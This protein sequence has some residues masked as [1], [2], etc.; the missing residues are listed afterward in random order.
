MCHGCLLPTSAATSR[1]SPTRPCVELPPVPRPP[2]HDHHRRRRRRHHQPV[3]PT[4]PSLLTDSE[5]SAVTLTI[6]KP[7]KEIRISCLEGNICFLRASKT[8]H[9]QREVPKILQ[10]FLQSLNMYFYSF[11]SHHRSRQEDGQYHILNCTE[12]S[13]G[14]CAYAMT[15]VPIDN[16]KLSRIKPTTTTDHIDVQQDAY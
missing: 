14:F 8:Q 5:T 10:N 12:K 1:V 7:T 15:K 4:A 6:Y 9:T 11:N 13:S 16:A 2:G 3:A